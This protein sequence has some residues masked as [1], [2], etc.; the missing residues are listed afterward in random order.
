MPIFSYFVVEV[1]RRNSN[2]L[3]DNP[4]SSFLSALCSALL[5]S[6]SSLSL[7][8]TLSFSVQP[9]RASSVV[10]PVLALTELDQIYQFLS[11]PCLVSFPAQLTLP[12]LAHSC[13]SRPP[14]PRASAP[15]CRTPPGVTLTLVLRALL[16]L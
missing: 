14:S 10:V 1:V 8:C 13:P 9:Y 12:A 6:L 16:R 5:L 3:C 2:S 11:Y 4:H 7:L 15:A